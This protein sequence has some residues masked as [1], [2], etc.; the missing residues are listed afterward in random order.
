[1]MIKKTLLK[2]WNIVNKIIHIIAVTSG[3]LSFIILLSTWFYLIDDSIISESSINGI[4]LIGTGLALFAFMEAY[5]NKWDTKEIKKLLREIIDKLDNKKKESNK[6]TSWTK[7]V[8]KSTKRIFSLNSIK[9][10]HKS[11]KS[12]R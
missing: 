4:S 9:S 5:L 12:K 6:T 10:S 7:E 11:K 8:K 3:V 2:I 1:M